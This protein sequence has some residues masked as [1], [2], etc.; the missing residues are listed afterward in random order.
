MN[1]IIDFALHHTRTVLSALFLLVG[2]GLYSYIG[3]PKES[4]PNIS[5][6]VIYVLTTLEGISPDAQPWLCSPQPP[7]RA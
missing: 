1:T 6:P 2:Y 4:D 7:W 3:L 5:L